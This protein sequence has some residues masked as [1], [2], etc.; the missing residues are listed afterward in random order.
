MDVAVKEVEV[1]VQG[2]SSF[3]EKDV[4]QPGTGSMKS[5]GSC[6]FVQGGVLQLLL[7]SAVC[8]RMCSTDSQRLSKRLGHYNERS[9]LSVS[10]EESEERISEV[11]VER[12]HVLLRLNDLKVP[13][14]LLKRE[15]SK[16]VILKAIKMSV[17]HLEK[18]LSPLENE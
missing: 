8:V 7:E 15:Q 16:N 11:T 6:V 2:A 10:E 1:E 17:K 18:N 14:E 9:S 13:K 4:G 5:S 3:L 12:D